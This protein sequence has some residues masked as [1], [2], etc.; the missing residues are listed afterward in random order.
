MVAL[1][2][3]DGVVCRQRLGRVRFES[4]DPGPPLDEIPEETMFQLEELTRSV[5]RFAEGDDAAVDKAG[6]QCLFERGKWVSTLEAAV[7]R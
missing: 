5:C 2:V 4:E 1:A 6:R 7:F 3:D